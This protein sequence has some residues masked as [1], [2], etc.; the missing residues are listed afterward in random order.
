MTVWSLT[1][2]QKSVYQNQMHFYFKLVSSLRQKF[3]IFNRTAMLAY[4]LKA[5]SHCRSY[6]LDRPNL[7][8]SPTK[9]DQA[10]STTGL[11]SYRTCFRP[12]L[13]HTRPPPDLSWLF[14]EFNPTINPISPCSM[15]NCYRRSTMRTPTATE[16]S[17]EWS[18]LCSESFFTAHSQKSSPDHTEPLQ[19]RFLIN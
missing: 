12:L 1:F 14:H 5:R 6:Q 7:P 18:L 4:H 17:S 2:I 11:G 10:Q 8:N 19:D 9:L 16:T 3:H 15:Y 13:D